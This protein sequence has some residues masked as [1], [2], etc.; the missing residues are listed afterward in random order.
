MF[1]RYGGEVEIEALNEIGYDIVELGN[2][3]FD[4]GSI[5]LAKQLKQAKFPILACNIDCSAVPD[6]RNLV[7]PSM[8]KEINGEKIA[9]I[10]VITPDLENKVL[11][12]DGVK[13]KTPNG[14]WMQSVKDEIA[15]YQNQGINKIVIVSHCG[16]ELDKHLAES[17]PSID[18]IVGGHS[19]TCLRKSIWVS[20]EDGSQTMIVQTGCNARALGNTYLSFDQLGHVSKTKTQYKLIPITE[21][22]PSNK[23]LDK[24]L[25]DKEK[26]L[27]SLRTKIVG[28][29]DGD[30]WNH[31]SHMPYDSAIG[32][33]I[34]DAMI[35]AV[36]DKE[37]SIALHN[38][39]GIRF[40]IEKG[41][42]SEE[43]IQEILPFNNEIVCLTISGDKLISI[44]EYSLSGPHYGGFLD[45]HGLRII[46]DPEHPAGKRIVKL[47]VQEGS[48]WSDINKKALYKI[49]VN[50]YNFR[51]GD[52]YDFSNAKDIDCIGK[53]VADALRAYIAKHQ[54]I[55]PKFSGRIKP[56][57]NK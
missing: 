3:E 43:N 11:E 15:Y 24:Y 7:K 13:I 40:K 9:F 10:G 33:L 14:D 57:S 19:H 16:V 18:L 30:F 44:L 27:L 8:V 22:L 51:G 20:H 53:R 42:I 35:E 1:Q 36:A 12:L 46:Y 21:A 4:K 28:F 55:K 37:V 25:T 34:C 38:R 31:F 6:L 52:G 26:P 2:H 17:I 49:A 41:P 48:V 54:H 39:G 32:N 23:Q 56:I 47:L 50:S 45:V 5:Y 29:S